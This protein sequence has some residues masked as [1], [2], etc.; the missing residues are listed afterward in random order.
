MPSLVLM[1]A[2]S[3]AADLLRTMSDRRSGQDPTT[4]Q[5]PIV[6]RRFLR[7]AADELDDLLAALRAIRAVHGDPA[8]RRRIRFARGVSEVLL[9]NRT[10]RLLQ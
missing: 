2:F 8:A 7:A 9:L 3:A 5:D 10:V 4:L 6:A 1:S